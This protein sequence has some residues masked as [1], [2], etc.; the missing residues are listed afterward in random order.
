ML[1]VYLL[2]ALATF[3]NY[4]NYLDPNTKDMRIFYFYD[5]PS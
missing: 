5:H 3:T 4:V 1:Q 2:E